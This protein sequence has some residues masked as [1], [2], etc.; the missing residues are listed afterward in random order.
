MQVVAAI[1]R[2]A[3]MI[4][5]DRWDEWLA[6]RRAAFAAALAPRELPPL[7]QHRT[8]YDIVLVTGRLV[9]DHES[10]SVWGTRRR[11]YP[12]RSGRPYVSVHVPGSRSVSLMV[13]RL[14]A[15]DRYGPLGSMRLRDIP[16]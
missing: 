3:S 10:G 16:M 11:L 1:R 13:N 5:T 7:P 12:N 14:V 15:T 6:P 8:L 9:V 2:W 4:P